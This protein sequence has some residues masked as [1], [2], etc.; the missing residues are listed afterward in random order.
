MP[1][2]IFMVWGILIGWCIHYFTNS[3]LLAICGGILSFPVT[4]WI[5]DLVFNNPV[6]L[7][8]QNYAGNHCCPTCRNKY[9]EYSSKTS[10]QDTIILKCLNCGASH[11]FDKKYNHIEIVE[12]P[13]TKAEQCP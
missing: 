10:E 12:I 3:L 7:K 6:A 13:K 2:P 8:F 5:L 11:R 1:I 9:Q 4:I